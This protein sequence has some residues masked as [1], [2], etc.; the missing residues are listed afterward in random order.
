[1]YPGAQFLFLCNP[2][3]QSVELRLFLLIK[4]CTNGIVVFSRDP[5]NL[6]SCVSTRGRQMERIRSSV[7]FMLPALNESLF[8][9]FIQECHKAARQDCKAL[10][11]FLLTKS[12]RLGDKPKY[13][14][15]RAT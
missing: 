4:G 12:W 8:L 11:E 9:K 10:P 14:G 15:V 1:M 2:A 13:P 3:E 7:F 6:F 5:S